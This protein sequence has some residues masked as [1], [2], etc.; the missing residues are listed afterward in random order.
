MSEPAPERDLTCVISGSFE[1]KGEID[2]AMEDFRDCGVVVIAPDA[3][4]L[5]LPPHRVEP[6]DQEGFRPLPTEQGMGP[7]EVERAFLAKLREADFVYVFNQDSYV[8]LSTSLE[9]GYALGLGKPIYSRQPIDPAGILIENP[10]LQAV[11]SE[12]VTVLPIS[13]VG[14]HFREHYGD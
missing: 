5:Y 1:F 12:R 7:G 13:E 9:I 14:T 4:W 6:A 2:R 8:G 3:G 11:I 10:G